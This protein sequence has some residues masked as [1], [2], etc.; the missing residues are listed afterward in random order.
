MRNVIKNM[1]IIAAT[2]S[3]WNNS[4]IVICKVYLLDGGVLKV[5]C[6]YKFLSDPKTMYVIVSLCTVILFVC[7]NGLRTLYSILLH[8][9]TSLCI[10]YH[11]CTS[12]YFLSLMM[13]SEMGKLCVI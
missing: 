10:H 2:L 12:T 6:S 13:Y 4:M 11:P 7:T 1:P 3:G 5:K 9:G 8:L